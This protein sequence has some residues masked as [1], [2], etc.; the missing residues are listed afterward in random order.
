MPPRS[1]HPRTRPPLPPIW[2]EA[3]GFERWVKKFKLGPLPSWPTLQA[4]AAALRAAIQ[5][6]ERSDLIDVW[7]KTVGY[8]P[9]GGP[10]SDVDPHN[11]VVFSLLPSV[12][13]I[14][15]GYQAALDHFCADMPVRVRRDFVRVILHSWYHLLH[16]RRSGNRVY[17]VDPHT[18]ELLVHTELPD[19]PSALLGLPLASFYFCLPEGLFEFVSQGTGIRHAVTGV[20][21][22]TDA[23]SPAPD[24]HREVRL[25][26]DG[27]PLEGGRPGDSFV[28]ATIQLRPDARLPEVM[29]RG[30]DDS[31]DVAP[32]V[33]RG[34]VA[35]DSVSKVVTGLCL[36][37]MSEHPRLEPV[38]PAPRIDVERIKNAGK[39][40]KAAE[41]NARTSRLGYIHVGASSPIA[42][43]AET[44]SDS[45]GAANR[46]PVGRWQL[47]HQVWVRGHWRHQAYGPGL[48]E[49]RVTWIKPHVK[50][51]AY[52]DALAIRAARVQ[53]ARLATPAGVAAAGPTGPDA[54]DQ[55]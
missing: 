34:S 15:T 52:A 44:V 45:E 40:R 48:R 32:I 35:L 30:V 4:E 49:H 42:E 11:E 33:D 38:P 16:F 22:T 36:Y 21:V 10:L 12:G 25:W 8:T 47:S 26:I 14:L 54:D 17:V 24:L 3:P 9:F 27:R 28:E 55:A 43:P 5:R 7:R 39:R 50:G 31:A 29:I 6:G 2:L 46:S 18:F 1:D 51:P 41:R 13:R 53:P 23:P 19:I 20:T 37:L